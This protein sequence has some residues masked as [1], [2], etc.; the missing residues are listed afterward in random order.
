[1]AENLEEIDWHIP[2]PLEQWEVIESQE[3][4]VGC[5]VTKIGHKTISEPLTTI[6]SRIIGNFKNR[7]E[8]E[9][10]LL[11]HKFT[12]ANHWE[13]SFFIERVNL[14]ETRWNT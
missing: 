8:A 7:S 13:K 5:T 3:I 14:F 4:I 12:I 10:F 11:E 2:I 9:E 6:Y 1:M